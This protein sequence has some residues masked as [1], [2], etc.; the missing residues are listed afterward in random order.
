MLTRGDKKNFLVAK[1]LGEKVI[2][3]F[4]LITWLREYV[5]EVYLLLSHG[6]KG[7]FSGCSVRKLVA[8]VTQG[9]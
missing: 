9:K 4:L 3:K 6:K 1:W 2:K 5:M 8:W 7:S